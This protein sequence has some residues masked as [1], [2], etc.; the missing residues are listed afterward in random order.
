MSF[1]VRCLD[2]EEDVWAD[3][4]AWHSLNKHRDTAVK[5]YDMLEIE[6]KKILDEINEK[7][8]KQRESEKRRKIREIEAEG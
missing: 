1:K 3:Q 8:R 2:C 6:C 4:L 7:Y 5:T